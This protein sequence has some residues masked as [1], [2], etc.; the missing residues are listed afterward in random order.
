MI[1]MKTSRRKDITHTP[2]HTHTRTQT[3]TQTHT[4]TKLHTYPFP[5]EG[6]KIGSASDPSFPIDATWTR[7]KGGNDRR[8]R[9]LKSARQ[10]FS[11]GTH[12]LTS[13][14]NAVTSSRRGRRR[15][16]TVCM[17][18]VFMSIHRRHPLDHANQGQRKQSLKNE[19]H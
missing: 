10:E 13:H 6:L 9:S 14:R 19:A 11:K 1:R 2:S 17:G 15:P 18:V 8:L 12:W 4:H 3:S 5:Q 16:L 7:H